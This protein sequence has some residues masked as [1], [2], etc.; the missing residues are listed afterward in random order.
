M[1]VN[2]KTITRKVYVIVNNY[3]SKKAE[4]FNKQFAEV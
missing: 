2:N 3:C 1:Q 4:F